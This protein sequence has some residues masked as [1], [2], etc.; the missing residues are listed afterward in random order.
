MAPAL[1]GV[2]TYLVDS[3]RWSFWDLPAAVLPA[4]YHRMVQRAG[5]LALLLPPDPGP[6]A[7][8]QVVAGLDGLLIAGGADVDPARYGA[9]RD[10]RTGEPSPERDTWELALIRAALDSGVPLLGV[11]RGMQLLNVALG[12]TLDQHVTGHQGAPGTFLSHRVSPVPGTLLGSVLGGPVDVPSC[13]HQAVDR[14]GAGL[15]VGGRADDGVVEAVEAAAGEA[16]V[17]GVQWHPEAGRCG[18]V[19]RALVDAA[20]RRRAQPGPS[21]SRSAAPSTVGASVSDGPYQV[22]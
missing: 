4:G 3:A 1:I 22:R 13:H 2:S 12:G 8:R 16:F 10:P 9:T 5:G 15:L 17:L 14:L 20:E 7:A 19:V 18:R 6:Q 11:C 21:A